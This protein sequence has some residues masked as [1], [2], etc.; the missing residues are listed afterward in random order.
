MLNACTCKAA[1]SK[2]ASQIASSAKSEHLPRCTDSSYLQKRLATA[3][4]QL[5]RPNTRGDLSAD[6]IL[7]TTSIDSTPASP[8]DSLCLPAAEDSVAQSKLWLECEQ[9]YTALQ[10]HSWL[11]ATFEVKACAPFKP[12]RLASPDMQDHCISSHIP[13][14]PSWQP[15]PA[16]MLQH[17][18]VHFGKVSTIANTEGCIRQGHNKC[19]SHAA[20]CT[21]LG[22]HHYFL[23]AIHLSNQGTIK[24]SVIFSK[25]IRSSI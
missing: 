13:A 3:T 2:A 7:R 18:N 23:P 19:S 1:V 17:D 10:E 5:R 20:S 16:C 12:S 21:S 25:L 11:K 15:A 4:A 24:Q 14:S 8:N 9:K 22:W 6:L